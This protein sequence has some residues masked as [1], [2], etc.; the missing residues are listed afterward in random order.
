MLF[1]GRIINENSPQQYNLNQVFFDELFP[2][3]NFQPD[4]VSQKTKNKLFYS[5]INI[6]YLERKENGTLFELSFG[7]DYQRYHFSNLFRLNKNETNDELTPLNYQNN[8]IYI[9]NDLKLKLKYEKNWKKKFNISGFIE[10]HQMFN[11]LKT[12]N[13]N[14]QN[15]FFVNPKL[16]FRYKINKNNKIGFNLF[17]NLT[18]ADILDTFNNFVFTGF[19]S[20]KRGTGTFNQLDASRFNINYQLG[21]WADK[22]FTSIDVNYT[23]NHNFFSFNQIIK[24][25]VS[26]T[27][28]ILIQNRKF[29]NINTSTDYYFSRL[30]TNLKLKINYSISNFTNSVNNSDL[31]EVINRTNNLGLEFRSVFK[32]VFNFHVGTNFS[33]INVT[34]NNFS[35]SFTNNN[36]FIDFSLLFSEFFNIQIKGEQ[37]FFENINGDNNNFFFLDTDITYKPKKSKWS[38][39]IISRN[40]TNTKEF[41]IN[42]INDFSSNT[43]V[44]NLLPKYVLMNIKYRF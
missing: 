12:S 2:N 22:F 41:K 21:N 5:G 33:F 32:S 43:I 26:I 20:F 4:Q 25:N 37:F 35:N 29:F 24:Q 16:N 42:T 1:S 18:N 27:E 19:R 39:S 44:Y 15:P 38:Y 11:R 6:H 7:N 10:I 3:I 31:R 23:I 13:I 17:Y 8:I 9:L 30:K 36:S 14:K 34:S 40:L 28:R